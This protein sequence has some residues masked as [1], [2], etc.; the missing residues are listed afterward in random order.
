MFEKS[1]YVG[2]LLLAAI[3]LPTAHAYNYDK[4]KYDH[5]WVMNPDKFGM[6]LKGFSRTI[7]QTV[8]DQI[9]YMQNEFVAPNPRKPRQFWRNLVNNDLLEPVE[10]FG[11]DGMDTPR[12]ERKKYG[13]VYPYPTPAAAEKDN[14]F[15]QL[16]KKSA[17]FYRDNYILRNNGY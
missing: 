15:N 11:T 5:A 7:V 6:S 17:Q 2:L 1:T 10:R 9:N 8:D 12:Y 16:D 4:D 13:V 14:G 3:L